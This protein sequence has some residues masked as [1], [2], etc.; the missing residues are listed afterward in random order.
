MI[1]G[2]SYDG[3]D[4]SIGEF[5]PHASEILLKP[6]FTKT[7][8]Y[9]EYVYKLIDTS[10]PPEWVDLQRVCELD[11][12]IGEAFADAALLAIKE[13]GITPDLIVS[14]GQTMYHW[15][16]AGGAALGTL[17]LGDPARVAEATGITVLSHLRSRDVAAGG[18]GA[19]FASLIDH[20]LLNGVDQKVAALNLGGISNM[21]IVKPG[22]ATI[23]YD[24]GP[25]SALIDAGVRIHSSGKLNYDEGGKLGAQGKNNEALLAELLKEPYYALQYPKSTGK[26]LFNQTYLE[27][28]RETHPEVGMIDLIATLTELT[29]ITVSNEI[30]KFGVAV[31]YVSGGGQHNQTLMGMM[32]SLS[33]NTRFA[34]YE[35]L[36]I[37]SDGKEAYLFGLIGFLSSYNQNGNI[38]SSTGASGGRILGSLSPG[39]SGFPKP[40]ESAFEFTSLRII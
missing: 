11:T 40:Y 2:T 19:P 34:P 1:S 9:P 24:V 16:S 23:A 20:M 36:G 27:K 26:E 13:S 17:Q 21:T 25:A 37:N 35:E 18:Q 22:S 3:I 32:R 6:L 28:I 39:K 30:N 33:P 29:A 12:L 38:P 8:E 31:I 5:T 10:M 4:C 14:H 15:I 7:I